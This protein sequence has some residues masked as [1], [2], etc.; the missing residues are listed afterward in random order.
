MKRINLKIAFKFISKNK[1]RKDINFGK[2][3]LKNI[4]E[5]KIGIS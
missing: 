2:Y 3:F 1:I 5:D 4:Y